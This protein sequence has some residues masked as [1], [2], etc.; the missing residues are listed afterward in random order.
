MAK[1][2]LTFDGNEDGTNQVSIIHEDRNRLLE[3]LEKVASPIGVST[4]RT[5]E[6]TDVESE[7][8]RKDENDITTYY[9]PLNWSWSIEDVTAEEEQ[10]EADRLAEKEER[11]QIKAMISDVNASDKPNWEKKL[12][13]RLIRDMKD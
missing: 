5:G 6:W 13:K 11:Q 9:H 4:W 8:S 7:I 1:F 10:K 2:K 3:K 12:L